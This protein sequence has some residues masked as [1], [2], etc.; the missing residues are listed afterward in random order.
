MSSLDQYFSQLVIDHAH[1][2][3]PEDFDLSL[4]RSHSFG[5]THPKLVKKLLSQAAMTNGLTLSPELLLVKELKKTLK[6][7]HGKDYFVNVYNSA[8]EVSAHLP[9]TKSWPVLS[10]VHIAEEK[11][12]NSTQGKGW[13]LDWPG[14]LSIVISETSLISNSVSFSMTLLDE[15]LSFFL[16]YDLWR[17][18]GKV[19]KLQ[20]N[21]KEELAKLMPEKLEVSGLV[22]KFKTSDN[23]KILNQLKN[24]GFTTSTRGEEIWMS[25]PM[26]WPTSVFEQFKK[27]LAHN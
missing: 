12:I 1:Q 15:T 9:E 19:K 17:L 3:I 13:I 20:Q 6:E 11:I 21:I 26:S 14:Y 16:S 2:V 7:L 27:A 22:F 23:D 4:E 10:L 5:P 8:F 24:S 25:V 18:D